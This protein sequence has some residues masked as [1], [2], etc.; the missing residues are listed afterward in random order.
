METY[1]NYSKKQNHNTKPAKTPLSNTP[2]TPLINAFKLLDT[3]TPLLES[4]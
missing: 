3:T 2:V 4:D 1:E